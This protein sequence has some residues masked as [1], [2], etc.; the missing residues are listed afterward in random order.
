MYISNSL[1]ISITTCH[2]ESPGNL[3][4]SLTINH[5]ESLEYFHGHRFLIHSGGTLSVKS[6]LKCLCTISV[7]PFISSIFSM[8]PSSSFFQHWCSRSLRR[9]EQFTPF[10]KMLFSDESFLG[11]SVP[12][13]FSRVDSNECPGGAE[14]EWSSFSMLCYC[15]EPS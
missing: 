3:L 13:D 10:V 11:T 4:H 5:W 6:S 2:P 1:S 8:F 14:E 9:G 7:G 12:Q 15:D